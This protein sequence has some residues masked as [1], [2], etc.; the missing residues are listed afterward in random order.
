[1]RPLR[2]LVVDDEPAIRALIERGLRQA[3]YDVVAVNDGAAALNAART[4]DI[5]YDL[6]VTNAHM[7]SMTGE[8]LI[9][10]LRSLFPDLAILHLD[11]LAHPL[12]PNAQSVPSLRKP[13]AMDALLEAV[14]LALS[15][16]SE[17]KEA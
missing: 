15:Q 17:R 8:Q 7:P 1:M 12:G 5:S 2:I 4:A 6:V 11:D 16:R 10:Q 13:F 14:A 3:G 9:G